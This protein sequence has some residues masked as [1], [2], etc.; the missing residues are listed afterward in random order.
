MC[1]LRFYI[2]S[3]SLLVYENKVLVDFISPKETNYVVYVC[4]C[5]NI[6]NTHNLESS[7]LLLTISG[8]AILTQGCKLTYTY[9]W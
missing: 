8:T 4:E 1:K 7:S 3:S 2:S 5:F 9:R 6:S